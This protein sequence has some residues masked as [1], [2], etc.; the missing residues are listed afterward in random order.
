MA[1]VIGSVY[2]HVGNS[3]VTFK[4]IDEGYGP[5]LEIESSAFGNL[6]QKSKFYTDIKSLDALIRLLEQAKTKTYS[7]P[8]CCPASI[9]NEDYED[10]IEHEVFAN[11]LNK[12]ASLL[13]GSKVNLIN[14]LKELKAKANFQERVVKFANKIIEE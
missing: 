7:E 1:K 10:I 2:W 14:D 5:T 3:G 9:P 12:I 8:Y 6:V 13:I 4:V 11:K